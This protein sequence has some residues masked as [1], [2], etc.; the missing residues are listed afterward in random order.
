MVTALVSYN[1]RQPFPSVYLLARSLLLH[2][3]DVWCQLGFTELSEHE[4]RG[5]NFCG[6]SCVNL[7]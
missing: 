1:V 4:D 6:M 7:G 3:P 2:W 5:R